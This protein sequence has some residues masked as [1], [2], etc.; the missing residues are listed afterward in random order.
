MEKNKEKER[1]F[2]Q[3]EVCVQECGKIEKKWNCF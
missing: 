1:I 2:I 3:M